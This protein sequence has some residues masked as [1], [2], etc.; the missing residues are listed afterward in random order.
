MM[1]K[2]II[3]KPMKI[4]QTQTARFKGTFI[5]NSYG[6]LILKP[7]NTKLTECANCG[8]SGKNYH[9]HK[10]S[11]LA[12]PPCQTCIGSGF[13]YAKNKRVKTP[14][15]KPNKMARLIKLAFSAKTI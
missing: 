7:M 12:L 15:T 9:A 3:P 11:S 14:K 8:G 6:N 13:V 2:T 1:Q 10:N 5:Q 4:N